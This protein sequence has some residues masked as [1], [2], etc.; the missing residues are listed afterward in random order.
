MQARLE[1]KS[2]SPEEQLE[3]YLAAYHKRTRTILFRLLENIECLISTDPVKAE[4][5][6]IGAVSSIR[7]GKFNGANQPARL[8]DGKHFPE[9]MKG[10][11]AP[12]IH[13]YRALNSRFDDDLSE[14]SETINDLQAVLLK[15]ITGKFSIGTKAI[16]SI[17]NTIE[18]V[19]TEFLKKEGTDPETRQE[20]LFARKYL[21]TLY[22]KVAVNDMFSA[23][24]AFQHNY[25]ALVSTMTK[26]ERDRVRAHFAVAH[27]LVENV[28]ESPIEP[29]MQ[30][31]YGPGHISYT[32]KLRKLMARVRSAWSQ[33]TPGENAL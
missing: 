11:I 22:I 30:M 29:F 7:T 32:D 16:K 1:Y 28:P 31:L 19:A 2:T 25:C 17:E 3:R 6:I 9:E 4:A 26:Q 27:P 14:Q 13:R 20:K 33:P 18:E 23:K 24:D 15:A 10:R 12:L 8:G 5:E 21:T